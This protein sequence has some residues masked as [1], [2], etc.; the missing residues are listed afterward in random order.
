MLPGA[1]AGSI[2]PVVLSL[3]PLAQTTPGTLWLRAGGLGGRSLSKDQ[4]SPRQ[5]EEKSSSSAVF[6]LNNVPFGASVNIAS[7]FSNLRTHVRLR[8]C[9]GL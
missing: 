5:L 1:T 9:A 2:H 6:L 4:E 7:V 3:Y 8:R